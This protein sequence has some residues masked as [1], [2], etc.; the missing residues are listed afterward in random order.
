[1]RLVNGWLLVRLEDK[2]GVQLSSGHVMSGEAF[3][4]CKIVFKYKAGFSY[5]IESHPD[6]HMFIHREDVICILDAP[7]KPPKLLDE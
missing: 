6:Q 3:L 1:M 7:K 5:T 2:R 4:G